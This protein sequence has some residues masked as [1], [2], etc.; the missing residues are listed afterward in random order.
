[1]CSTS[2]SWQQ[3]KMIYVSEHYKT[4]CLA[5]IM[6]HFKDQA[7]VS[8]PESSTILFNY[9]ASMK[10]EAPY[11]TKCCKGKVC[12]IMTL[13]AYQAGAY[14]AFLSMKLCRSISTIPT[15]GTLV[16]HRVTPGPPSIK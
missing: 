13:L 7:L 8:A 3:L 9:I 15:D 6:G 1:M 5:K 10:T 14:P 12:I 16:D 2:S 11:F 4:Q